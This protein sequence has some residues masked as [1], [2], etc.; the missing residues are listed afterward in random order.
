MSQTWATRPVQSWALATVI[1]P[2]CLVAAA[3]AV[4]YSL[5]RCRKNPTY[6]QIHWPVTNL[7]MLM[8]GHPTICKGAFRLVSC[9]NI[10]GRYFWS[11]T[12]KSRARRPSFTRGLWDSPYPR[13]C[14][15][16]SASPPTISYACTGWLKQIHCQC[17]A[18]FTV[19]FS[20]G[21]KKTVGGSNCGTPFEKL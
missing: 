6:M 15:W 17:T 3:G 21:T 9:R 12:W 11:A 16:A 7:I 4:W 14:A 2:P 20:Q 19:F 18:T 10:A 5:N 1:A 13:C 8:L